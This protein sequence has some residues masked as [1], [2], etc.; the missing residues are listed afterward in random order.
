MNICSPGN[1]WLSGFGFQ[2]SGFGTAVMQHQPKALPLVDVPL[3]QEFSFGFNNSHP[4]S[5]ALNSQLS[6]LNSSSRHS[7]AT[8]DQLF[9]LWSMPGGR[10]HTIY[11]DVRRF[12]KIFEDFRWFFGVWKKNLFRNRVQW[13]N[14]QP[15]AIAVTANGRE[16]HW[17]EEVWSRIRALRRCGLVV[18]PYYPRQ[19]RG[20]SQP[21][22]LDAGGTISHEL[23]FFVYLHGGTEVK[24]SKM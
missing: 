6:T 18:H 21:A 20:S 10:F 23:F 16:G 2:A 12:S 4:P 7:E 24:W 14:P 11:Q 8:A 9:P 19:D 1:P 22:R 13:P 17:G 5:Y 15:S 3:D